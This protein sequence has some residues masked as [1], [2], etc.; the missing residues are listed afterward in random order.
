M[1]CEGGAAK[2]CTLKAAALVA[3]AI[4]GLNACVSYES[5][6]EKAVYDDEPVYCYQS[7]GAVDCYRKPYRRDDARLVNYYG[8]APT[9]TRPPKTAPAAESQAPP[10][11]EQAPDGQPLPGA[12]AAI[13]HTAPAAGDGDTT[14]ANWNHWLPFIS[15]GFGALQ[16]IAAFVL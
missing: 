1:G 12:P 15:V 16:V 9:R 2:D 4:F 14:G 13:G 8:P 10:A 7:L 11:M 5:A 6:Y 3:F